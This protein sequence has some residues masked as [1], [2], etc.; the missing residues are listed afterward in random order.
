MIILRKK[1]IY[2]FLT[3]AGAL[4]VIFLFYATYRL[5]LKAVTT[6]AG[7]S[8]K[9]ETVFI[10]DAG[11]GGIDG[12]AVGADGTNEKDIN[13]SVAL[14]LRDMMNALGFNT[15]TTRTEDI[16][17]C[18]RGLTTIREK[19]VSDIHNRLNLIENTENAVFISIHQNSYESKTS[20]GTQV[21][22]SGKNPESEKLA[23]SV[24]TKTA[25]ILQKDNKRKIKKAGTSIYLL[26]HTTKPAVMVE[27]GFITNE[28]ECEKL[29]DEKYQNEISFAIICGIFDYLKSSEER[30]NGG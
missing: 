7:S 20:T 4:S 6:F 16:M 9:D 3:A 28:S 30:L 26:Y 25:E 27:C 2:F 12:G 17:T 5:N 14:K 23:R 18:D 22:Y 13:L 29:K 19:K 15:L 8:P 10:I 21:F 11:H 1:K 24:Q